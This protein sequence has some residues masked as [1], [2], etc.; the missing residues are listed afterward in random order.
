MLAFE[1]HYLGTTADARFIALLDDMISRAEALAIL[2]FALHPF[3]YVN[4]AARGQD[5]WAVMRE[6]GRLADVKKVMARYDIE[7]IWERKL[8]G[9]FRFE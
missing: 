5:V 6:Q 7:G 2:H 9:G 3:R 4:Y 8:R 1:V